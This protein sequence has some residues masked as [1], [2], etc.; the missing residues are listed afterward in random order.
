[1]SWDRVGIYPDPWGP[2]GWF[3][4]NESSCQIVAWSWAVE[5]NDTCVTHSHIYMRQKKT[6]I[7]PGNIKLTQG[8]EPMKYTTH[9]KLG[10][11]SF[12]WFFSLFG[13]NF[14]QLV[15]S[16]KALNLPTLNSWLQL[17]GCHVCTPLSLSWRVCLHSSSLQRADKWS[18][19]TVFLEFSHLIP[20]LCC[21]NPKQFCLSK[22][23]HLKEER[24]ELAELSCSSV[25]EQAFLQH[26]PS[27]DIKESLC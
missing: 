8:W 14:L 27:S 5:Q 21:V 11:L 23:L 4:T 7:N 3:N 9:K 12:T 18:C 16:V 10:I 1:M 26:F 20:R 19:C 6:L 17:F 13:L 25:R 22:I 24:F 15:C 2:R